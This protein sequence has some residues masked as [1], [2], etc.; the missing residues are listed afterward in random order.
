LLDQVLNRLRERFPIGIVSGGSTPALWRSHE[1]PG[2][3]EIRPGTYIFNDLNTVLSGACTFEDCAARI[4]TT[5][6]STAVPGQIV[7]DGGSKTFSS[8]RPSAADEVIYGQL[9]GY[10]DAK[11]FRLNE[12]HGWVRIPDNSQFRVGQRIT[13]LPVHICVA[14]NLQDQ[15]YGVRGGR[16]EEVWRV[17]ARG[18]V[19]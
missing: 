4:H 7:L 18:K 1:F 15:V 14:V 13:V 3:N 6:I 10:P 19:Q 16:V 9:D 8:D 12:E 17:E 11:L 5:I 2:L